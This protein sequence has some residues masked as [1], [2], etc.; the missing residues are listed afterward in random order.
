MDRRARASTQ[1]QG[2]APDTLD[3]FTRALNDSDPLVRLAA[4][5]GL[6]SAPVEV[7]LRY[8]PRMASDPVRS[9]RI[10]AARAIGAEAAA[11]VPA[12]YS[13][14]FAKAQDEYIAALVYN[15]DRPESQLGLGA[16]RAGRGDHAGA[17]AAFEKAIVID[18][19]FVPAYVNL[20]DLYRGMGDE[21][22]AQTALRRG[23]ARQPRSAALHHALG[24]SLG[25]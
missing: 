21:T 18:S 16:L 6:D 17:K 2:T 12:Q 20:A 9:V 10:A 8:L 22:A 3:A 4:A 24:L 15:A 5:E 23:I 13:A 1:N 25:A 7:R 14:A 19:T 11:Q